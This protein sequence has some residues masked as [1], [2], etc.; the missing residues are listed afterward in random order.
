MGQGDPFVK[1]EDLLIVN[2]YEVLPFASP[3]GEDVRK[4]EGFTTPEE[5]FKTHTKVWTIQKKSKVNDEAKEC[6]L[7]GE[8]T[9]F[10]AF[11]SS[12][13]CA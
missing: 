12:R 7:G 1:R 13:W 9:A 10:G 6:A 4:I 2:S 5:T 3:H 8:A 11:G